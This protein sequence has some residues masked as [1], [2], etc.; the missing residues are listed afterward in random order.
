MTY[1][2]LA[3]RVRAHLDQ[4]HRYRHVVRV[5]RCCELLA[6][7]H[8]EN[9]KHARLAGML[10]DL[11]RLY[12]GSRL[13]QECA[14]RRIPVDAFER[15]NPIVLHAQLGAALA[16]EAFGIRDPDVLSAIAKHT[17]GAAEMSPLDCIVY[18]ADS[19]EPGREFEARERLWE[20]ALAD[21]DA[22]MLATL[23][24]SLEYLHR[25]GLAAAPQ[26]LAARDAFLSRQRIVPS[27][28]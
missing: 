24:N 11:A 13:L 4:E 8:G 2:D 9:V 10:H 18:L 19:L 28:N 12:P 1:R 15:E 5:A 16:S 21:L 27:L 22:A 7:R 20:L 23:E 3:G 14:L 17:L 26:T 25:K 6:M